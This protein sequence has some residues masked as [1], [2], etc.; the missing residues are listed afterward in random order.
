MRAVADQAA[1]LSTVGWIAHVVG[2]ALLLASLLVL[3]LTRGPGDPAQESA[4]AQPRRR[5][6]IAGIV[7]GSLFASL[8]AIALEQGITNGRG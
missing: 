4:T 3:G 7:I 2:V 6:G 8:C 1:T 5:V